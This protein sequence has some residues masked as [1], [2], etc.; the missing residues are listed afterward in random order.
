MN[1]SPQGP[2]PRNSGRLSSS[3]NSSSN[4][5]SCNSRRPS[6]SKLSNSRS[7][8]APRNRE[9]IALRETATPNPRH[10]SLD[11]IPVDEGTSESKSPSNLGFEM[12]AVARRPVVA[13]DD[14]MHGRRFHSF[15]RRVA[16]ATELLHAGDVGTATRELR[17]LLHTPLYLVARVDE[18]TEQRYAGAGWRSVSREGELR[19]MKLDLAEEPR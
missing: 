19:V 6:S 15:E 11:R 13:V 5:N 3:N 14:P 16:A 10:R 17:D 9:A 18:T 8:R 4:N 2:R 12:P 7:R 1:S